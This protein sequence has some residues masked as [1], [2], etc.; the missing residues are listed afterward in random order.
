MIGL[1]FLVAGLFWLWLSWFLASRVPKWL[2]ISTPA[3]Q[4][5]LSSI[6]F[7]S[8]MVGPF[9]DHIVGMQQF[10][11]LCDEQTELQIF[12]TAEKTKKAKELP[13]RLEPLA[14]N[15]IPIERQH[16]KIIDADT[17]EVIATYDYF[18]TSGGRLGG[19]IMLGG[20]YTCSISQPRH[21]DHKKYLSF[22]KKFNLIYGSKK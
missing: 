7:L 19:L 18:T 16:R 9:A 10:E 21:V 13:A 17:N 20:Q 8:L 22:E 3:W 2:G 5:M 12:S 14:G 1:S 6:L 4:W 11:R 15:I